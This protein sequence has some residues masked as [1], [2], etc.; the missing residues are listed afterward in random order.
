MLGTRDPGDGP[1]WR[2]GARVAAVLT[3]VCGSVWLVGPTAGASPSGDT[4]SCTA[5]G[6]ANPTVDYTTDNVSWTV[7]GRGSCNGA[8]GN[9]FLDFSGTGTSHGLSVCT[10]EP[11]V[12]N[13]NLNVTVN[14]TDAS[15]APGS[16]TFVYQQQWTTPAT[17]FPENF[18]WTIQ[19]AGSVI[20]AGEAFSR[21]YA[22]CPGNGGSPSGN[23]A[24]RFAA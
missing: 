13:L 2:R 16:P 20:G 21:I 8:S 17:T 4:V 22:H 7:A 10:S 3:V 23:F 1:R 9:F 24:I 11:T 5:S 6:A 19:S 18:Q 15:S 12:Q 14:L